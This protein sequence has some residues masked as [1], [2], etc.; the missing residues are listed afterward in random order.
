MYSRVNQDSG[1]ISGLL[2]VIEMKEL[3]TALPTA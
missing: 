1:D 3:S 2:D